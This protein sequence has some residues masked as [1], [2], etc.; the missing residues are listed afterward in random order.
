MVTKPTGRPRGRPRKNG[1]PKPMGRRG[2]PR[3][4]VSTDPNRYAFAIF[5][6]CIQDAKKRGISELAVVETLVGLAFGAVVPT[7]ENLARAAGGVAHRVW[8]PPYKL[9][10]WRL[11]QDPSE[12]AECWRYGN[13]FRPWADDLRRNLRRLRKGP[14]GAWLRAM[15]SALLL[16]CEGEIHKIDE[17]C[18]HAAS[19]GE[20]AYFEE[21]LRPLM[22]E[23]RAMIDTV[24]RQRSLS[25]V[26]APAS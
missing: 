20:S 13:A 22:I 2:R 6:L 17:A 15:T 8:M 3:R 19:V 12:P 25:E 24:E 16:C 10:P 7:S 18:A 26:P 14:D 23:R 5:E 4:P 21:H 1:Q 11:K 9:P